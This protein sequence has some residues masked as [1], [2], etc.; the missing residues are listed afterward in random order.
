MGYQPKVLSLDIHPSCKTPGR[1][2][3]DA[4]GGWRAGGGGAGGPG[5]E[6]GG[7]GGV[8]RGCVSIAGAIEI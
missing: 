3:L 2:Y 7:G 4:L 5:G 8:G 6:G 1:Q